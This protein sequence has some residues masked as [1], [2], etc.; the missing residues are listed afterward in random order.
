MIHDI[1]TPVAVQQ[2]AIERELKIAHGIQMAMLPKEFPP[3][4]E[5]SDIDIYAS[6][7]PAR[8][9]G[10]DLYD[11]FLRGDRLFFCIG[12]V[13][14]KGM[15]AALIMAVVR[16]MFRSE[17]RRAE[18]AVSIVET[19]NHNF[20]DEY[21]AGYFVTMFVGILDLNTGV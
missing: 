1:T 4:P 7:T 20:S 2:A 17:T 12:D 5:R 19:M 11:Y 10:G 16:A 8:E 3:Y 15:P 9:V 13:S 18:T 21:T 6:E 14:G